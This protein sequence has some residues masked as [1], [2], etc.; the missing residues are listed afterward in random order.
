MKPNVCLHFANNKTLFTFFYFTNANK[1]SIFFLQTKSFVYIFSF[2]KRS[3]TFCR[4]EKFVY[5]LQLNLKNKDKE[6]KQLFGKKNVCL[7]F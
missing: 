7:P 5:T 1:R 6:N 3:F 2:K 4:S